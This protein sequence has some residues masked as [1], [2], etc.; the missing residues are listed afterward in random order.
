MAFYDDVRASVITTQA[1]GTLC[2]EKYEVHFFQ[3]SGVQCQTIF[4]LRRTRSEDENELQ[5][6]DHTCFGY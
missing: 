5:W 4:H 1:L 3:L 2:T 6:E